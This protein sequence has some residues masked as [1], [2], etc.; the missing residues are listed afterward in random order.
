MNLIND[1]TRIDPKSLIER[2]FL[3]FNKLNLKMGD[4]N[5]S[6]ILYMIFITFL[7]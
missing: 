7:I 3:N 4:S 2:T 6:Y 5:G 1:L